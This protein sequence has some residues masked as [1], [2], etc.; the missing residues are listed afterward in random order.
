MTGQVVLILYFYICATGIFISLQ[1]LQWDIGFNGNFS[2]VEENTAKFRKLTILRLNVATVSRKAR[3]VRARWKIHVDLE[4]ASNSKYWSKYCTLFLE[5]QYLYCS[6]TGIQLG[7]FYIALIFKFK[8][9]IYRK[10]T[11]LETK[12]RYSTFYLNAPEGIKDRS[13]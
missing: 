10:F 13:N 11:Y 5:D 2:K 12:V 4:S 3:Q 8:H 6:N 1:L 9:S 7:H